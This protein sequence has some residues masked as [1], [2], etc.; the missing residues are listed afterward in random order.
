MA[1]RTVDSSNIETALAKAA[2]RLA[3]RKHEFEID[4]A[5]EFFSDPLVM[6]VAWH[7]MV[8]FIDSSHSGQSQA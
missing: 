8:R 6:K 2:Q 3:E 5:H 1:K 7:E 4:P